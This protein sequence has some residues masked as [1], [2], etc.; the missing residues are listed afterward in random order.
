M[1][2]CCGAV[3][4]LGGGVDGWMGVAWRFARVDWHSDG[5]CG[6]IDAKVGLSSEFGHGCVVVG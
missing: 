1:F 5:V 4:G 2:G 6:A 3:D